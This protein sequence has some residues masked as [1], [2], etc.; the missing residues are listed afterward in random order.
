MR[1]CRY[2]TVLVK[3]D[4]SL[5]SME[6][7]NRLTTVVDL[8]PEFMHLYISNCINTCHNIKVGLYSSDD[9]CH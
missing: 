7:V 3:M 2:L 4:M 6:V 1:T 9:V 8:P 5:H